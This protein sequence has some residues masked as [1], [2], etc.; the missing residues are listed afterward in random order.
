LR[1]WPVSSSWTEPWDTEFE[2]AHRF[3]ELDQDPTGQAFRD[4]VPLSRYEDYV[5]SLDR[6]ERGERGI[7]TA[8]DLLFF[9]VS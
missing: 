5:D 9:A 8:D 6:M 2:K 3:A 7:V 1:S 4:R